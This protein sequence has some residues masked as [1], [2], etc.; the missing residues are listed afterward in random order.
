MDVRDKYGDSPQDLVVVREPGAIRLLFSEKHNKIL[1][2]LA[3]EELSISDIA[4]SLDFNP[5][6]VHYHLKELE[7][8]GLVR[9][10][11][12]EIKGGIVKKYYR[13][14][15]WRICLESPDFDDPMFMSL[16]LPGD[17]NENVLYSLKRLGYDVPD[18]RLADAM[19][20]LA[21]FDRRIRELLKEMQALQHDT[22]GP[23]EMSVR[24]ACHFLIHMQALRDPELGQV[25]SQ[26]SKV[27]RKTD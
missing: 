7:R 15:A 12:Q 16:G 18:E 22:V 5:G 24:Y 11:R 27:F 20:V 25:C 6:S 10:V 9:Q 3:E 2:K 4:R 14:A 19:D 23:D 26:F 13:S 17:L 1:R 21:R 8:Q